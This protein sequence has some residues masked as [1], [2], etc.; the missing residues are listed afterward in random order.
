MKSAY[1]IAME[2]LNRADAD[3]GVESRLTD[4]QKARI[5]DLRRFYEAKLAEQELLHQSALRKTFD[6]AERE[7]LDE[8]Y[9]RDREPD[10]RA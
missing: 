2:R 9:R 10:V 3:A 6:P 8:A 5:A 1:E 7:E 4:E